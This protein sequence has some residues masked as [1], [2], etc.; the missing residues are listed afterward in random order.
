MKNY[1]ILLAALIIFAIP[2]VSFAAPKTYSIKVEGKPTNKVLTAFVKDVTD[3]ILFAKPM[4]VKFKPTVF[5][6]RGVWSVSCR[7][8]NTI[9]IVGSARDLDAFRWILL[10]E[11]TRK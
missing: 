6:C 4:T 9:E 1:K 3:D 2:Q 8:G 10:N 11:I 7:T 5:K